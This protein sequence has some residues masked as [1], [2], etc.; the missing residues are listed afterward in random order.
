MR[1]VAPPPRGFSARVPLFK[2]FFA[3]ETLVFN[4]SGRDFG[5]DY[6]HHEATGAKAGFRLTMSLSFEFREKRGA[7]WILWASEE[8]IEALIWRLN[9]LSLTPEEE[10]KPI[11]QVWA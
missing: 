9:T 5:T 6:Q 4:T 3:G 11:S 8:T 2:L 7:S 10:R 1:K